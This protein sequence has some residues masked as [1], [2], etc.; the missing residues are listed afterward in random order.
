MEARS[1]G[2]L[3]IAEAIA[4]SVLA[5]DRGNYGPAFL[6][7]GNLGVYAS[8][9]AETPSEWFSL[10]LGSAKAVY[11][12]LMASRSDVNAA[13]CSGCQARNVGFRIYVGDSAGAPVGSD[14]ICHAN[15]DLQTDTNGKAVLYNCNK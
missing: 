2:P 10:D 11:G 15:L 13:S 8:T 1:L 4:S 7:D 14:R 6:I 3:Y 9:Q 5:G 12:L